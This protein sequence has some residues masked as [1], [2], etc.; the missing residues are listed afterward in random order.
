MQQC[1]LS[2]YAWRAALLPPCTHMPTKALFSF[3]IYVSVF[4]KNGGVFFS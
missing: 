4:F 3:S 1:N 2:Y